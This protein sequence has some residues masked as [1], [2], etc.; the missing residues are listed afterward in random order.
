MKEQTDGDF[1][2]SSNGQTQRKSAF[3][4][5]AVNSFTLTFRQSIC[6]SMM[7]DVGWLWWDV[8]DVQRWNDI[9]SG[10]MSNKNIS[11]SNL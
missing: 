9:F 10:W 2:S 8:F 5:S 4:G 7:V 3:V 1:N 11:Q 6:C